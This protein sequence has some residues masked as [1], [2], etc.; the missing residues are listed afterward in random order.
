MRSLRSARLAPAALRRLSIALLAALTTALLAPGVALAQEE[1]AA[2]NC[3]NGVVIPEPENNPE[4]V[5]DCEALL[6]SAPVLIGEAG[7]EAI[8]WSDDTP[9]LEWTGVLASS[10]R[11]TALDLSF[12]GLT[13]QLSPRLGELSQL[14]LISVRYN[15]LSGP[16]PTEF[17]QLTNLAWLL[18]YGNQLTG[19]I[20]PELGQL[21]QLLR[22][23][24]DQNRLTGEIP[25]ELGDLP[26]L[27]ELWLDDNLL[28][29]SIPPALAGMSRIRHLSL[30]GNALR[31]P[32]PSEFRALSN[33]QS[34][35]ASANNLSGCVVP[36]LEGSLRDQERVG[37]PWCAESNQATGAPAIGGTANAGDQLSAT[38]GVIAGPEGAPELS[39]VSWQ[40]QRCDRNGGECADLQATD[41]QYVV[42][43]ADAGATLRVLA[44]FSDAEGTAH[45]PLASAAI[46]ASLP[47]NVE[48]TWQQPDPLRASEL[49]RT[50]SGL[51]GVL[52]LEGERWLRYAL[53]GGGQTVPGSVDFSIAL[54]DTIWLAD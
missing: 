35:W 36:S 51:R 2:P 41:Q 3:A 22:I 20:P 28:T 40:W 17:A 10:G 26:N 25:A 42:V 30:T 1:S 4:L 52:R 15:D 49:F 18:L 27:L 43:K 8:N 38:V 16:I 14:T 29:G 48:T 24:L 31:G 19:E 11:V 46:L 5:A 21:T 39:A 53:F 9:I 47:R 37:V 50:E 7:G 33:L 54:G 13:G 12:M 45:G 34:F 6:A 44:S 32:V 23:D